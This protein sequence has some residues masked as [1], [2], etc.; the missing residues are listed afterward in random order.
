[1]YKNN[2]KGRIPLIKIRYKKEGE[3]G[4]YSKKGY[5]MQDNFLKSIKGMPFSLNKK[6]NRYKREGIRLGRGKSKKEG[7]QYKIYKEFKLIGIPLKK[8]ENLST[9]LKKKKYILELKKNWKKIEK[10]YPY[11]KIRTSLLK[12]KKIV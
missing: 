11:I 1:M 8:S 10:R 7:H 4:I 2:Q 9:F 12:N 5:R 6:Y 3:I